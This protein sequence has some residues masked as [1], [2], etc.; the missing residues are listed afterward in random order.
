MT[1]TEMTA[2]INELL[3]SGFE[4]E[5]SQL[6]PSARLKE[7]LMLDS[8]D[9]VDMLVYLEDTFKIKVAGERITQI[10]TMS[11]VYGLVSEVLAEQNAQTQLGSNV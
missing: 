6:V 4:L 9:A 1:D 5:L 11:D 10:K 7:D 2:K 3:A 8:L